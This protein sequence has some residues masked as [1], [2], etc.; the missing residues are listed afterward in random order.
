M[1]AAGRCLRAH[2]GSSV[3]AMSGA[4]G[5]QDIGGSCYS[6]AV[7]AAAAQQLWHLHEGVGGSAETEPGWQGGDASAAA[8]AGLHWEHSGGSSTAAAGWC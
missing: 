3:A 7:A 2:G 5:Q 1:A 6:R 8:A 4:E